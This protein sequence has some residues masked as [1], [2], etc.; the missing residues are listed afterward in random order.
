MKRKILFL[1]LGILV[2]GLGALIFFKTKDNGNTLVQI[3]GRKITL[4]E[5]QVR[6]T[7][8]PTYYQGFLATHNGKI[9]LLNG[10]IAEAVLIQK[11]KEEGL[12]R[13]E[14]I[15]RMLKNVEDRILLEAIVQ[16][17][18]KDRIAVS[19][20]EVKEYLEKNEEKF[21][22]PEQMRVSHILVKRKS[23]AKKILNELKEGANFEKLTR[24]YSIDS[25]TAPRGG[26]L[27]YISRG[28]MIP[29]FEEAVF[30]LENRNDISPI[31]ETPFGYHLVKL[32]GRKK[33]RERT[34]EEIDSEIRTII[35]NEKLDK[36]MEKYRKESM[37][38]VNYDLLDKVSV[39]IQLES[40]GETK[41]EEEKS[42]KP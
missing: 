1:L 40:K 23:E 5:F 29:A 28:E 41:N 37:V 27:G 30:A 34:P 10:M 25:I 36:L 32:T 31:I 20:E 21:A 33:M 9:E 2:I 4:E 12:H 3:K 7:E 6:I 18:Q 15:R 22:S 11:A 24:K 26:D 13:K 42:Q 16:E 35:Q 8:I 38:S 39:G 14:E 17:L 19:D